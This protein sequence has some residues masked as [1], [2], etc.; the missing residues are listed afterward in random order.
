[1]LTLKRLKVFARD[2]ERAEAQRDGSSGPSAGLPGMRWAAFRRL[3]DTLD[4][5]TV[6]AKCD[7]H[8]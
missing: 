6:S 3:H 1:M 7:A 5:S 4:F 8:V 2:P